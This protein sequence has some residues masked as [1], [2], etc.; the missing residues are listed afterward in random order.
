MNLSFKEVNPSTPNAIQCQRNSTNETV[1]L[2][3]LL[4]GHITHGP[5]IV[6]K[7]VLIKVYEAMIIFK[8]HSSAKPG[9]TPGVAV[10]LA[11]FFFIQ[12]DT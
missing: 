8:G 6:Q 7:P 4:M 3:A 12:S 2:Q 5:G 1:K 11:P 10:G 9:V